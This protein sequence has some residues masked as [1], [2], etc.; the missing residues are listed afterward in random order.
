MLWQRKLGCRLLLVHL[1]LGDKMYRLGHGLC[2]RVY[3]L[4]G[5]LAVIHWLLGALVHR[6][7]HR[8][9]VV[10]WLLSWFIRRSI[11]YLVWLVRHSGL[12]CWVSLQLSQGCLLGGHRVLLRWCWL[13][14]RDILVRI[15]Q[16]KIIYLPGTGLGT[17]VYLWRIF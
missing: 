7:G 16:L 6:L 12:H 14:E 9:A 5:Y 2:V 17:L 11:Y 4:W 13:L 1:L 15:L 10:P 3:R 8:L